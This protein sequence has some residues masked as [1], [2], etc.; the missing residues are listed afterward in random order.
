MSEPAHSTDTSSSMSI[1]SH[2]IE[3]RGRIVK[4]VL[5]FIIVTACL[6]PFMQDLFAYLSDPLMKALPDGTKLLAVGV[7]SPVLGPLKTVLFC[8]FTIS[9]PIIVYE[10]WMFVAPGLYKNEKKLLIP[11]LISS[12]LMF[13]AGICYC[14]FIVFHFIFR[15]ISGFAPQAVSFAPDIDSYI[16]FAIHLFLAFGMA[17]EVP[18]AVIVLTAL[19]VVS[20]EK[21]RHLRRYV[22]VGVVAVAAVITPPDVASQLLLAIPMIVLYELGL[23]LSALFCKKNHEAKLKT[24]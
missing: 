7:V 15:F 9:L 8:A 3:L 16:S 11:L 19:N 13:L 10:L 14:Y 17:F 5:A 23:M 21:M 20:L 24:A 2:L 1:T 12:F 18:I 22:I 4:A 6:I